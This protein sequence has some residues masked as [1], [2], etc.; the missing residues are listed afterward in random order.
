MKTFRLLC[1]LC[2]T[3][4]VSCSGSDDSSSGNDLP[5]NSFYKITVD[6]NVYE[7]DQITSA[8]G[9]YAV[10]T[11]ED[12]G[13]EIK[14]TLLQVNDDEIFLTIQAHRI[15]GNVQPLSNEQES[16]DSFILV[17]INDVGYYSD[18]GTVTILEDNPYQGDPNA[19]L[20]ETLMEFSGV[21]VN[22]NDENDVKNISGK[23]YVKKIY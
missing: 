13:N 10:A 23:A 17:A 14:A 11:D 1:L 21:F 9:T 15:D 18:S 12:T 6:G 5:N 16:N 20:T 3:T 19:G 22:A 8:L 2:I 4:L 7:S